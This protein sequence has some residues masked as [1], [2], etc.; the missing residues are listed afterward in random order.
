M[1]DIW[2]NDFDRKFDEAVDAMEK[3]EHRLIWADAL[4]HTIAHRCVLSALDAPQPLAYRSTDIFDLIDEQPTAEP[5]ASTCLGCNCPK[6]EKLEADPIK[7]GRWKVILS[8]D[9]AICTNC[10]HYW[11]PNGD[12]YDYK[13]C[14]NCGARMDEDDA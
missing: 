4:K 13:Y 3:K 6:M 9:Y 8:G 7:H 10:E 5:T 11:I 2:D 1:Y 14:P 12:Q